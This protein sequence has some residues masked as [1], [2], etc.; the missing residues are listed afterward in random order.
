MFIGRTHPV[1]QG[2]N[3]GEAQEFL[4]STGP[5]NLSFVAWLVEFDLAEI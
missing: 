1:P 2:L 4:G 3:F 5:Q